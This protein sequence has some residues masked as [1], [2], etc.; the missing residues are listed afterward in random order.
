MKLSEEVKNTKQVWEQVK[1][2]IKSPS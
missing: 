2:Q 1:E